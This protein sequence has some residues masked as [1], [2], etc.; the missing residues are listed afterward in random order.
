MHYRK[1]E[2]EKLN[3]LKYVHGRRYRKGKKKRF[4]EDEG[5]GRLDTKRV[6]CTLN[7]EI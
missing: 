4:R 1:D 5:I 2:F 6:K 3:P 7:A